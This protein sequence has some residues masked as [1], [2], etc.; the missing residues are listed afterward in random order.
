MAIKKITLTEDHIKLIK[1][2]KFETFE[3]GD[4]FSVG[5]ITSAISEIES[6]KENMKKFGKIRD[7]LVRIKDQIETISDKKECHAWGINQWSMFGGTY[8]MEDI[9]M[10]IGR[11]Q[12]FIT[13]T[14]ESNIGK[15]YPKELEDYMW[16]L[17]EYI[18]E[19][20]TFIMDLVLKYSIK[21]GLQVGTYKCID[22]ELNWEFLG[23]ESV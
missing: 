1:G 15:Q 12:D 11:Y 23:N 9:A 21:G 6:S 8:V 3:M 19:N 20:L 14:E 22:Y 7:E 4:L 16:E 2:L 17:Y 13:G 5:K 18:Y 10:L